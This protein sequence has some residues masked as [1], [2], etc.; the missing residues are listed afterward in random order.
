MRE[1]RLGMITG[2]SGLKGELRV[3]P[4]TD[5][6]EKFE[7]LPYVLL[8]GE[9]HEIIRVRYHKSMAVL[10]LSGIDTR[11]EA[12][13]QR[14]KILTF[15][16]EKLE[17]LPEDTYYV[18]DLLGFSVE[19]E[20]GKPVGTLQNVIKNNAVQDLYEIL[21]DNGRT[22]LLP[23]VKAFVRQIDMEEKRMTVHLIQ[24]L[25]DDEN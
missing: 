15:E 24:G 5:Y 18:A 23:A 19:D 3:Y 16:R 13:I 11:E 1:I 10:K 20:E 25:V 17:P 4:Y 6:K 14:G 7:E 9:A 21:R 2:V 12:E 8:D 22:F